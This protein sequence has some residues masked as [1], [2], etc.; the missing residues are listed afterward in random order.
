MRSLVI[1]DL[2]LYSF[3]EAAALENPIIDG[4]KGAYDKGVD[5][6]RNRKAWADSPMG[7]I[8]AAM[9][10]VARTVKLD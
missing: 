3:P 9:E 6:Y 1:M 5:F 2:P 7:R 8:V 10:N 4:V